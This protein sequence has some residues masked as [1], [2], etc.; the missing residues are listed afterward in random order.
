MFNRRRACSDFWD[1]DLEAAGGWSGRRDMCWNTV[2][3]TEG[4]ASAE[5][6][7]DL[8]AVFSET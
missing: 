8:V 3:E 4:C 5:I 6:M 1:R 7:R 2:Q